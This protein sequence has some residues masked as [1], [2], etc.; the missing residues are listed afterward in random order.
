MEKYALLMCG[1]F[2]FGG[3][4]LAERICSPLSASTLTTRQQQEIALIDSIQAKHI[5]LA[6]DKF[7]TIME[8]G[9]EQ[10]VPTITVGSPDTRESISIDPTT[11]SARRRTIA[12]QAVEENAVFKPAVTTEKF[13]VS[14]KVGKRCDSADPTSNRAQ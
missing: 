6:D 10:G 9:S 2:G 14:P 11:I 5:I 13:R 8:L 3:G 12:K 7:R 1:V 4:V